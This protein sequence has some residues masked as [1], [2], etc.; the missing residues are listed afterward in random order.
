MRIDF[1]AELVNVGGEPIPLD[2]RPDAPNATLSVVSVRALGQV[3]SDEPTLSAEH[4]VARYKLALRIVE[5]GIQ[6]VTVEEA[7]M[8]KA[9]IGK[10]Y[11]P[12][13]VGAA[14]SLIERT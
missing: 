6:E 14:F 4:K 12:F 7:A 9:V 10:A 1:G 11:S 13:V 5:G 2:A 8:L 3:F